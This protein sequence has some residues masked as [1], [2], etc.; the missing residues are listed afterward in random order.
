MGIT[1]AEQPMV[2]LETSAK[3]LFLIVGLDTAST[4]GKITYLEIPR[5]GISKEQANAIREYRTL[6]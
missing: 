2:L 4:K 3:K 1:A 6:Q 5:G